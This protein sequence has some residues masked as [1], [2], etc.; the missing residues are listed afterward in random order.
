LKAANFQKI[1][2]LFGCEVIGGGSVIC[3]L[4]T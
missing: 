3:W 2:S 1:S 4:I